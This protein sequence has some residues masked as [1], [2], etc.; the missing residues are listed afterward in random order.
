MY[1]VVIVDDEP[2]AR[3][4]IR[5]ALRGV[6]DVTIVAECGDG[7]SAVDA[8]RTKAPDVV[9]LD[10][11]MPGMDA[12]AVIE[13]I[14]AAAMPP[15]VFV[16]AFDAHAIRAF[17]VHALDYVLKPFDDQRLLAALEH[18]RGVVRARH[19]GE[20]GRRLAE[21]LQSWNGAAP[22]LH[23]AGARQG[24]G[25]RTTPSPAAIARLD[26]EPSVVQYEGS[27][28]AG[29]SAMEPADRR[30][31]G[32]YIAR[33][34]VREDGRVRFV[35][36]TD[37]DWI[38]ADGNYMVLHVGDVRH[39]VRASLRDVIGELDPKRFARIHRSV[40]V[41]IDR[42]RELQPWFGGDYIAILRTGAK[43]KVSR[44]RVAQLLRPM[45]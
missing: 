18:A 17:E 12:F 1:R 25:A 21:V 2:L 13:R 19:Q 9:F 24:E 27:D 37:V 40:I 35:P 44:R 10:V 20:L 5:L 23:T 30:H 4:C 8:I 29:E 34:A 3:D 6:P 14:G 28:A 15:V 41:N 32:T 39:R 43:L 11:Q 22:V 45:A 26:M 36:A 7:V 38:E 42:I 33:F 31:P 16:T